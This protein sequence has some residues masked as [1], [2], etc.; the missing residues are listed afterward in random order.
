MELK[1][2]D[3]ELVVALR[4]TGVGHKRIERN[5]RGKI[6]FIF[7]DNSSLRKK[8]DEYVNDK[9][10]VSARSLF[11]LYRQYKGVYLHSK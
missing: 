2:T 1:T 10:L 4:S 11:A 9:L 8:I 6:V 7:D 3:L 5:E